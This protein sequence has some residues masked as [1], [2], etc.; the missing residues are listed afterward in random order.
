MVDPL[1]YICDRL[2]MDALAGLLDGP[3]AHR[4]FLLRVVMSPPWSITVEDEAPL[5]LVVMT[6]GTAVLT[7]SSGPV[8]LAAGDVV[9]AR[10]PAP[11]VV[12]DSATTPADIRI[13]PGQ[14]C[15]DPHG[16]LLDQTM[17]LGVRTWGN[18]VDGETV[19]L[20]GTYEDATE[21]GSRVLSRLPSDVVLRG[22]DSPLVGLLSDEMTRDAPGQEA[23][24]DRLLDLLLVSCLRTLFEGDDAPAWYAAY[25]DPVVGKAVGLIHHHPEHPWTVAS[26]AAACGASRAAFA[27]RFTELVGEP[28]LSFLT[29]WRLALAADLLVGSDATLASVAA[30]VGYGNAFALSAAFKRRHGQSP[31]EYRRS[32]VARSA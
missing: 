6:R 30:Q 24:L 22:V 8:E 11:Y 4:A 3:R 9:L 15:I 7:G 10:G 17:A 2:I 21:I 25:D 18:A 12:A 31:T 19:M 28:P 16:R 23:V 13:L 5:T 14:Q 29:G 1:D 26:L 32:A 20:I 27:R